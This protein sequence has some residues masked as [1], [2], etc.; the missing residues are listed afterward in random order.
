[1]PNVLILKPIA[2]CFFVS[3]LL[4]VAVCCRNIRKATVVKTSA[5]IAQKFVD[6][7]AGKQGDC[8]IVRVPC[9][10]KLKKPQWFSMCLSI[11]ANSAKLI[12]GSPERKQMIS[13]LQQFADSFESESEA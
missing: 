6:L 3:V 5:G 8:E 11:I 2:N 13:R 4:R 7:K 9:F 1:M 10:G 12:I